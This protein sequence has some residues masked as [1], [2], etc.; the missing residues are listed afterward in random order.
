MQVY[1][2]HLQFAIIFQSCFTYCMVGFSR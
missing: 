1:S 2:V